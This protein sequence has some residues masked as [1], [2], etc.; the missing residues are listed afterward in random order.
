[1]HS[2]TPQLLFWDSISFIGIRDK[3]P[4]HLMKTSICFFS[5]LWS[6]FLHNLLLLLLLLLLVLCETQVQRTEFFIVFVLG[7]T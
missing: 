5:L 4:L 6:V 1:M 7:G 3:I 2:L